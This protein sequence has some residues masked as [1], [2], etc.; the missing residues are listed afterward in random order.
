MIESAN[1]AS[2]PTPP[3]MPVKPVGPVSATVLTVAA[4]LAVLSWVEPNH[5]DPWTSF[6]SQLAMATGA[7]LFAAWL[8]IRTFRAGPLT[9]PAL[10]WAA[11]AAAVVP[12]IQWQL[13]IVFFFGDAWI[14][15]LYLL[16]FALA[17]L[18]GARTTLALD[19]TRL[20]DTVYGVV[21]AGGFLSA[22]FALYQWLKL[23]Y[24]G[25]A[26]VA[27]DLGDRIVANVAQS[28]QLATLLVCAALAVGWLYLSRRIG[29]AV[30]AAAIAFL[31][32]T[33]PLTG[34]RTG[35]LASLG[36]VALLLLAPSSRD[37]TLRPSTI[38]AGAGAAALGAAIGLAGVWLF[39]DN[40]KTVRSLE[41]TTSAGT[42]PIHWMSMVDAIARRPWEGHGWNQVIV[43]HQSVAADHPKTGEMLSSSHNLFLDLLVQNGVP[44]GLLAIA[45]LA[46]SLVRALRNARTA[47]G[48]FA[49]APIVAIGT[50]SMVE[51]PHEYA[52]FLVVLGLLFGGLLSLSASRRQMMSVPS[53]VPLALLGLV[54]SM[55]MVTSRDYFNIEVNYQTF[56]FEQ[57]RIGVDKPS[58]PLRPVLALTQLSEFLRFART[59][60]RAGM[61]AQELLWFEQIA[62]RYPNWT[63]LIRLASALA[64]NGQPEQARSALAGVCNTHPETICTRAQAVWK[65][66]GRDTPSVAAVPWPTPSTP[67]HL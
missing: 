46:V 21:L 5:Y 33:M 57:A 38:L 12:W 49:A 60:A 44:L 2:I 47:V 30:A 19:I 65:R 43:A 63:A 48:A 15:S 53:W 61:S 20:L 24:L 1:A 23:D 27:N 11:L 42:R 18:V 28:N 45:V 10:A 67:S 37:R 55:L 51:F 66:I 39:S 31:F 9:V 50:H 25:D 8:L 26:V 13:G 6:Q 14:T 41:S 64:Q 36:V 3:G 16:G 40:T 62:K 32:I 52:T 56:R 17:I 29:G 54:A 7:L 4:L 22:W 59:D 58:Q 35:A 34:S